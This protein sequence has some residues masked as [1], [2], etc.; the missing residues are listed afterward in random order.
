MK[1]VVWFVLVAAIMA[2]L[3]K[4]R[5]QNRPT[6][7]RNTLQYPTA[8]LIIGVAGMLFSWGVAALAFYSRTRENET[9][10]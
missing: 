8:V 1:F 7:E 5:L 2:W 3:G 4:S 10:T 9:A 6:H